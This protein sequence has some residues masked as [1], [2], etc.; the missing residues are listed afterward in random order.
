MSYLFY[1]QSSDSKPLLDP[2]SLNSRYTSVLW[3]PSIGSLVPRGIPRFPFA[4][5]W[6]F[7]YLRV[8]HN[9][10][11]AIFVVYD[12][13]KTIHRSCVFPGYFR[14]PFMAKDDL[15]IGDTWTLPE[16][17][18]QGVASFAIR[19]IASACQ[20]PRRTFWYVVDQDNL[21]SIHAVEKAG[22]V[23]V[24]E[25]IRTKRFGQRALGAYI[26]QQPSTPHN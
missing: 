9:R 3:R 8:F 20:R 12:G 23:K 15:Q 26:I 1:A 10:D 7:H 16:C 11:Y 6:F 2:T 13:D 18:G 5:W 14:F 4:A 19:A 22:F 24:G 21:A 25:G 17:R